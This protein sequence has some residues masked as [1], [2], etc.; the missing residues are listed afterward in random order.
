MRSVS[1]FRLLRKKEAQVSR[2]LLLEEQPSHRVQFSRTEPQSPAPPM[3][4]YPDRQRLWTTCDPRVLSARNVFDNNSQQ[5]SLLRTGRLVG[6]GRRISRSCRAGCGI[7]TGSV[8]RGRRTLVGVAHL[9]NDFCSL[10]CF[11]SL[12]PAGSFRSTRERGR[13]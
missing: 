12:A 2:S 9:V 3:R 4:R 7:A 10:R 13:F 8:L 11:F 1:S 6:S 5:S